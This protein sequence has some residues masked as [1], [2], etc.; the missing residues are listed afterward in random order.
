MHYQR[1]NET[2]TRLEQWSSSVFA[3]SI[4]TLCGSCLHAGMFIL[5]EYTTTPAAKIPSSPST[6]SNTSVAISI[7][8]TE[9]HDD[10]SP[11]DSASVQESI[12]EGRDKLEPLLWCSYLG[13]LETGFMIIWAI[14]VSVFYSSANDSAASSTGTL[15]FKC[16]AGVLSL[17]VVNFIHAATFFVLLAAVGATSSALLKVRIGCVS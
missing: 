14:V 13:I 17:S 7:S 9:A 5:S 2:I 6:S 10:P 15:C 3:G 11:V 12:A 16:V 4:L 8:S 1:L